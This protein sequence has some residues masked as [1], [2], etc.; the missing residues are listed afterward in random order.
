MGQELSLRVFFHVCLSNQSKVWITRFERSFGSNQVVLGD[1]MLP[2]S[3]MSMIC[4]MLT[5]KSAKATFISSLLNL[6]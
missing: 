2:V 4:F 3:A 6:R 5:G 1:M